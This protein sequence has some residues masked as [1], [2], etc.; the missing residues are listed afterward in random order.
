MSCGEISDFCKELEQFMKFYRNL[1]PFCSKFVWRK[2]CVEKIPVE[3]N[4]KYEVWLYCLFDVF[5][6]CIIKKLISRSDDGNEYVQ[7]YGNL[8]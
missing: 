1:C 5:L 8:E 6:V 4:D 2:I 7:V 3:K